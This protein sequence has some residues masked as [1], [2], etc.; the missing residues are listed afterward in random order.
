MKYN[1]N[2][3]QYAAVTHGLDLDII[4]L[5]IFDFIKD[6]VNSNRCNKMQTPEGVY[7]WVSHRIVM[8]EMPLLR[9]KTSQGLLKR[10][11]NLINAGLL[12][13]HPNCKQYKQTLYCFGDNYELAVFSRRE[14]EVTDYQQKLIVTTNR[15][16]EST[17]NKSCEYY[18]NNIDNNIR[19]NNIIQSDISYTENPYI[20]KEDMLPSQQEKKIADTDSALIYPFESEQ[21]RKVW[22]ILRRTEKWRKKTAHALQL[23]LHKLAEYPEEFRVKLMEDAIEGNWQGV[24]FDGTPDA[25]QKWQKNNMSKKQ[26]QEFIDDAMWYL[27]GKFNE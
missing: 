21:G 8:D 5:A 7:F 12:K 15:S 11:D 4:D 13:R 22:E 9:I 14:T 2:I 19:D 6:F 27:K 10:I 3:N 17:T 16:C 23:S 26:E 24:V 1:I 20:R 18:N 25:F